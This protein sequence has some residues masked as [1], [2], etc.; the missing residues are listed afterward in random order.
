M[1]IT[2]TWSDDGVEVH[3]DGD[4]P[5][6][7]V[8]L[9]KMLTRDP[10]SRVIRTMLID[11]LDADNFNADVKLLGAIAEMDVD[12]YEGAPHMRVAVVT[13]NAKMMQIVKVYATEYETRNPG[14]ADYKVFADR[15]VARAWLLERP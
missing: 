8:A 15:A 7:M 6:Q 10:R 5:N 4:F 9:N 3:I 13:G 11:V 2:L 12:A 14:G 1:A